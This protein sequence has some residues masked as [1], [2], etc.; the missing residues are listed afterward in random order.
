M[1]VAPLFGPLSAARWGFIPFKFKFKVVWFC[2]F[3]RVAVPWR[4]V[5]FVVLPYYIVL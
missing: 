1:S 3:R 4:S 5:L 2:F